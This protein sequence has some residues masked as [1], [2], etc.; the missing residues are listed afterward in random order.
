MFVK[1][2]LKYMSKHF[3]WSVIKSCS[4][5][6]PACFL[7]IRRK[8]WKCLFTNTNVDQLRDL[9]IKGEL[10]TSRFRSICWRRLLNILPS[11]SSIWLTTIQQ[12]RRAYY[13]IKLK[14][15]NDPHQEDSGPDDPLSQE[16]NVCF[17]SICLISFF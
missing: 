17:Q 9:A 6:P 14:H 2:L 1:I 11:N 5:F 8:E 4:I 12:S 13:R 3:I 7:L 16:D 10:R 15:H